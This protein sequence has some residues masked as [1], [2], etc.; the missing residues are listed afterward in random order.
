[1]RLY[2]AQQS[3]LEVMRHLRSVGDGTLEGRRTRVKTLKDAIGT[4]AQLSELDSTADR[5]L[6]HVE[7]ALHVYVPTREAASRT[8]RIIPHVWGGNVPYGAFVDIGHNICVSSPEFLFAQMSLQLE[9]VELIM[10]GMELCGSYSKW[11]LP[12]ASAEESR[13]ALQAEGRGVTFELRPATTTRRLKDFIGRN[14]GMRGVTRTRGALRYVLDS[15]ASPMETATCLLLNLPRHLGGY[16]LPAPVLNPQVTVSTSQGKEVRYPD[17]Y[18]REASLDVEYQSDQEHSGEW[19][20]YRD[21]KRMVILTASHVTV[22]PLTRAQLMS[23]ADFD[24]FAHAVRKLLGV[25]RRQDDDEWRWRRHALRET[26]LGPHHE[27]VHERV[28][29]LPNNRGFQ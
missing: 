8:R 15:S 14:E 22:L 28:A 11:R 17:L 1:M 2:L 20:R 7:G 26:T 10:L 27:A 5:I 4:M 9:K 13:L 16:G 24:E 3:A 21:S 12:P 6:S 18:W 25:R 29:R 23:E 19:S